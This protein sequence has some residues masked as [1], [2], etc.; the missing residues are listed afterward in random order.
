MLIHCLG[1]TIA[2]S[3][4]S[5]W[6]LCL[7]SIITSLHS[8]KLIC[9]IKREHRSL[10]RLGGGG[11]HLILKLSLRG[12]IRNSFNTLEKILFICYLFIYLYSLGGHT[13][14]AFKTRQ[15]DA[16]NMKRLATLYKLQKRIDSGG[17]PSVRSPG[18]QPMLPRITQ[19]CVY[20]MSILLLKL[21][22]I[23]ALQLD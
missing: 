20:P 23:I 8:T 10:W 21:F 6:M 14:Y 9:R 11:F 22:S 18:L 4:L 12:Y 15:T 19:S 1:P 5:S 2:N 16:L 3:M 7:R 13:A 17:L